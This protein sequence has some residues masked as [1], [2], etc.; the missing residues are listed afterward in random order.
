ML[1]AKDHL[2]LAFGP[3]DRCIENSFKF[4]D[5]VCDSGTTDKQSQKLAI[6]FVDLA[7][8]IIQARLIHPI[9]HES[10]PADPPDHPTPQASGAGKSPGAEPG[11]SGESADSAGSTES[12]SIASTADSA[13]FCSPA[14]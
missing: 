4:T 8:Q 7:T 12:S 5:L 13:T 1:Q 6:D 11:E 3:P 9:S 10:D 14:S 2:R